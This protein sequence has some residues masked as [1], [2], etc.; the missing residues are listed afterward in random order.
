MPEDFENLV[1]ALKTIGIPFA[2]NAWT[3]RPNSRTYGIVSLDF[4]TDADDGENAKQERAF[5]GS[6]DLYSRD[7]RGEDYPGAI[8]D[9]LEEFCGPSWENSISG[10]WEPESKLFRWE[11]TFTLEREE[12]D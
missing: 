6:I 3:P 2:E 1:F 11:W 12:A 7:K 10:D 8:E 4:E 9:L 5:E